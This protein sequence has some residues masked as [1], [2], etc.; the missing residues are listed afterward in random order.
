MPENSTNRKEV[1]RRLLTAAENSLA[2]P[3]ANS[4]SDSCKKLGS[5]DFAKLLSGKG[6]TE[7]LQNIDEH[8]SDCPA[9][10]A[11]FLKFSAAERDRFENERLLQ[12]ARKLLD[13]VLPFSGEGVADI[14]LRYLQGA[15]ELVATSMQL[16][17]SHPV[18][19]VRGGEEGISPAT[20]L[21]FRQEITGSP[22]SVETSF[23]PCMDGEGIEYSLSLYDSEL[24]AFVTG[25]QVELTGPEGSLKKE[26]DSSGIVSFLLTGQGYYE[27]SIKAGPGQDAPILL[28]RIEVRT[29]QLKE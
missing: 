6:S 1:I 18:L 13:R 27:A 14:I 20:R 24:E 19:T 29:S 8:V 28:T 17:P 26:T 23:T 5:V 10:H 22:V 2:T 4:G 16:I 25:K 7:E 3:A 15:V 21:L 11:E 12:I 9:C